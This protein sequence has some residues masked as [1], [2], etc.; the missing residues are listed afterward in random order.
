M[1]MKYQVRLVFDNSIVSEHNT[2]E[3][4]VEW[5]SNNCWR[6]G[7]TQQYHLNENDAVIYVTH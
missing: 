1:E 7:N 6:L 5:I 3:S 2:R 4:L